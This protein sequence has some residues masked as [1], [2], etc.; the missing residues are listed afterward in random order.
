MFP[1]SATGRAAA[2]SSL[3][4][5]LAACTPATDTSGPAAN[6]VKTVNGVGIEEALLDFYIESRFNKAP[7]EATEE[8]RTN[9]LK[10]ITDIYLLTT[11][12][13]AVELAAEPRTKAQ[14]EL[15]KRGLLA[16]LT[17]TDY[18][19]NN[20]ATE[21]EIIAEYE[22]QI[23]KAPG[24]QFKARHI[25]V[26]SQEEAQALIAELQGGADFAELAMEKSTGPSGPGGGDLGWF[27]PEQMVKPFSDAVAALENGAFT[28]E[29]VETQFG[30][31]VILREDSRTSEPPTLESVREV[32]KQRVEQL[33]FQ[34]Y[35]ESL[36]EVEPS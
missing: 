25:L 2:F 31:H 14:L 3:V 30:F 4:I 5:V 18:I 9:A 26:E 11:Q 20:A 10:E 36:R 15:Q 1:F 28:K 6:A 8:E 22:D 24:Q 23:S 34:N 7:G 17:A 13:R 19:E 35:L 29:P 16:Q 32:V 12:P 21:D 33:K 27:P